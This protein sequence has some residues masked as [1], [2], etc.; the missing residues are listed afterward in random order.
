LG[1]ELGKW[2][3]QQGSPP[4]PLEQQLRR[5]QRDPALAGVR[6]PDAL[7]KLSAAE[8]RGWRDFWANVANILQRSQQRK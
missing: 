8:Q 7:A 6:D 1:D 2:S 3:K 4:P 5:W